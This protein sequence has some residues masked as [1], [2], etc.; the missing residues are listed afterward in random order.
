MSQLEDALNKIERL[1]HENAELKKRLGLSNT[2]AHENPAD[3]SQETL[4]PPPLESCPSRSS[5]KWLGEGKRP[6][7]NW[8]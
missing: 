2:T 8:E 6:I 1:R 4:L 5:R 3:Y 7:D